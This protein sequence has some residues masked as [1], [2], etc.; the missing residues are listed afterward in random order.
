MSFFSVE[1]SAFVA[2]VGVGGRREG[3]E[4][5]FELIKLESPVFWRWVAELEEDEESRFEFMLLSKFESV[6]F[7]IKLL[8][9]KK[10][11]AYCDRMASKK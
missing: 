8:R 4:V 1:L 3:F 10:V 2:V 11:F 6:Y 7:E 9:A 5:S